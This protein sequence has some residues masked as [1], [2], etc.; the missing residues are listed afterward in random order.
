MSNAFSEL[1]DFLAVVGDI[2]DLNAGAGDAP[3]ADDPAAMV[4]LYLRTR[5]A[6]DRLDAAR[7]RFDT[8]E[9]REAVG[10]MVLAADT[11]HAATVDALARLV[12]GRDGGC[13]RPCA[14]RVGGR[15]VVVTP[16]VDDGPGY[17]VHVLEGAAIPALEPAGEC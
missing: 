4:G 12:L 3:D 10:A 7:D 13:R 15:T 6:V 11:L 9:Y 14:A 1:N 8:P 5:E 17:E 16:G 2:R